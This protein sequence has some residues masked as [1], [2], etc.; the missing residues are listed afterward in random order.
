MARPGTKQG[1]PALTPEELK[2]LE[3]R[4]ARDIDEEAIVFVL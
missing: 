3:E 1:K 4:L 2:E